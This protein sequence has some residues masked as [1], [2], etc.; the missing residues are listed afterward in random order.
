MPALPLTPPPHL[1]TLPAVAKS[2][3]CV[4]PS[5]RQLF[6]Q[7]IRPQNSTELHLFSPL[8][9][10][11][12]S[13]PSGTPNLHELDEPSI[14]GSNRETKNRT[15]SELRVQS[16]KHGCTTCGRTFNRPS[17]LATHMNTHTGAEPFRC[18]LAGCSRRFNVESNMRRHL[19]TRHGVD[20]TRMF[21]KPEPEVNPPLTS[22]D[23]PH[24]HVRQTLSSRV[25][26]LVQPYIALPSAQQPLS[27]ELSL[28][29][30]VAR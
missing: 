22:G 27:G 12:S 6:P 9:H 20:T 23:A 30:D 11:F 3:N 25:S 26:F 5:L 17:S 8:K 24:W 7:Y 15:C 21:E 13:S 14:S 19:R 4:L 2:T 29:C 16:K 10:N 18:S 1:S 28:F